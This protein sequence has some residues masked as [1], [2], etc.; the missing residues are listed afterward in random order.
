MRAIYK[1]AR[2]VVVWLGVGDRTSA[3]IMGVR[4]A[5]G[6]EGRRS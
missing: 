6:D 2:P 3:V 4:G 1:V 5:L